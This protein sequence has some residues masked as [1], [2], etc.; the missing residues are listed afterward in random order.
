MGA[1]DQGQI[2]CRWESTMIHKVD[3]WW[4]CEIYNYQI[5]LSPFF[6]IETTCVFTNQAKLERRPR[7]L[8]QKDLSASSAIPQSRARN[9]PLSLTSCF[10]FQ[11]W[12]SWHS[13]CTWTYL[14]ESGMSARGSGCCINLLLALRLILLCSCMW[15]DYSAHLILSYLILSVCT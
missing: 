5:G 2:F 10:A 11:H 4:W 3:R 8:Q 1:L 9:Q 15:W 6:Q 14:S 12:I 7:P 13:F